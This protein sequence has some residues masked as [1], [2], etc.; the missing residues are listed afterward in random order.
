[1]KAIL[2]VVVVSLSLL[3]CSKYRADNSTFRLE[4][5]WRFVSSF[6][7]TGGPVVTVPAERNTDWFKFDTNGNFSSNVQGYDEYYAYEII[8]SFKLLL[9]TKGVIVQDKPYLY[10]YDRD[11]KLLVLS[12]LQPICIEGC[13]M[14]FKRW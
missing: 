12:Q 7:G 5:K 2:L 8:D 4:G 9:K 6:M 13:G 10:S 11:K 3:A 1:M 14:N